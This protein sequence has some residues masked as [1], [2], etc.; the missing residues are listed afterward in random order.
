MKKRKDKDTT[1]IKKRNTK[2]RERKTRKKVN[3]KDRMTTNT[4]TKMSI[5][6]KKVKGKSMMKKKNKSVTK[7]TKKKQ[8]TAVITYCCKKSAN[9]SSNSTT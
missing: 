1:W 9:V 8:R 3:S 4:I 6:I 7:K 2:V 5:I